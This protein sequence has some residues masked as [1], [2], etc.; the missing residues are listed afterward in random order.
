MRAMGVRELKNRLSEALRLVSA[1]EEILVT[2]RGEV[3]A[4]LRKPGSAPRESSYPELVLQAQQ[5]KVRL[6]ARNRPEAYPALEPVIASAEVR[7]LL[8][9]ERGDR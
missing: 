4:E 5:G 1:G 2:D 3:V 7:R 8:D 6:G 9:E